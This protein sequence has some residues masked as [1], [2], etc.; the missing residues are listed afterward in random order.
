MSNYRPFPPER[1]YRG[2]D[3]RDRDRY[4]DEDRSRGQPRRSRSRSAERR[5]GHDR[6]RD[7]YRQ[8]REREQDR[9]WERNRGNERPRENGNREK[10]RERDRERER[11]RER[12]RD[13]E[14]ARERERGRDPN[15]LSEK[16]PRREDTQYRGRENGHGGRSNGID[17]HTKS[18]SRNEGKD[19]EGA[20]SNAMTKAPQEHKSKEEEDI[21]IDEEEEEED[22]DVVAARLAEQRRKR[23]E[24]LLRQIEA[25][26]AP[27]QTTSTENS[28]PSH[29]EQSEKSVKEEVESKS[30]ANH[31]ETKMMDKTDEASK[32]LPSKP[33]AAT[34]TIST[35][36]VES[37]Q[38]VPLV[39][40]LTSRIG[41]SDGSEVVDMF[42]ATEEDLMKE[43]PKRDHRLTNGD[44]DDTVDDVADSEGYYL[45]RIGD[46]LNNRY[47]VQGVQGKGVF[48][49]VL[50]VEDITDNKPYVVKVVRNRNMMRQAGLREISFLRTIS[51]Q[52]PEKK[53]HIVQLHTHFDHRGHLCL[54]FDRM[55]MNLREFIRAL[56]GQGVS[57]MATRRCARQ[58]L[59]ALRHLKKCGIMHADIKPDNIL[60]DENMTSATL[61]DL[62]SAVWLNAAPA[63]ITE[64][65][66]SRFYR[67]PE[68]ILGMELTEAIDM[69]SVGCVLYEV[70]TGQILFNGDDNN[71][72]LRLML[73]VKGELK[74][75]VVFRGKFANKHFDETGAFLAKSVDPLTNEELRR[76]IVVVSPTRSLLDMLLNSSSLSQ[77]DKERLPVF[78]DLLHKMLTLDPIKRISPEEALQHPFLSTP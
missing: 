75:K 19:R 22:P 17:D 72:M 11:E 24:E 54:V 30:S 29:S 37:K 55:S 48:S 77:S 42:S 2:Y 5:G 26:E 39:P 33:V 65:V 9:G 18:K 16:E 74:R 20:A 57:L 7:R 64:Y 73:E 10:D 1:D 68:I 12:E 60:V 70:F 52:D 27:K 43:A 56:G 14:R 50:L 34:T 40:Q 36:A 32:V 38:P 47:V 71:E 59:T 23:R 3:P 8:D 49:N 67:A 44:K 58:V 69:W 46:T 41:S 78:A 15:R 61:C 51:Q 4:R 62:G 53:R 28:Q 13:R 63:E 45:F 25:E 76:R 31:V 6:D 21:D 66:A 35:K